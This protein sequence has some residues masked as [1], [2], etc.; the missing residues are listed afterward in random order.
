MPLFWETT[1]CCFKAWAFL[2]SRWFETSFD[3]SDRYVKAVTCNF[4][5]QKRTNPTKE[6]TRQTREEMPISREG[7]RKPQGRNQRMRS[8]GKQPW[9]QNGNHTS[10][11]DSRQSQLMTIPSGFHFV[12][13]SLRN[14]IATRK[15]FV[16]TQ[17]LQPPS[18]NTITVCFHDNARHSFL[19]GM[20]VG[21]HS[22]SFFD[23]NYCEI[24][25][26]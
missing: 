18:S 14:C 6:E 23:H 8:W 12:L 1:P 21:A 19:L 24:F 3:L 9:D 11:H 20:V 2:R 25:I 10:K 13:F 5:A 15:Y 7:G 16:T 26:S 4:N 17:P 22:Q